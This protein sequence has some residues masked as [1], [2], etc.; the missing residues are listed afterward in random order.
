MGRCTYQ[1]LIL[2]KQL[3]TQ[4]SS[5]KKHAKVVYWKVWKPEMARW[6]LNP[7]KNLV[8]E[9]IRVYGL[10]K[11]VFSVLVSRGSSQT[12]KGGRNGSFPQLQTCT[13]TF[14]MKFTWS[15]SGK[16]GEQKACM[17]GDLHWDIKGV[18]EEGELLSSYCMILNGCPH[19]KTSPPSAGRTEK[20]PKFKPRFPHV[21]L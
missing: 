13:W 17:K 14:L 8:E 20:L 10:D 19:P 18:S 2:N 21:V 11:R 7:C 16:Q 1:L 6:S 9:A 4:H 3:L 15:S 12:K 5:L